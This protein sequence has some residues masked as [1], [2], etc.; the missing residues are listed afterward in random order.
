MNVIVLMSAVVRSLKRRRLYREERKL[1][2][3][4][5]TLHLKENTSSELVWH[6]PHAARE[7]NNVQ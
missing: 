3:R 7:A 2:E 4:S 5:L 1:S 6:T